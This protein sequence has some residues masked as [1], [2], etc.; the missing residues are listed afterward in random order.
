MDSF[1]PTESRVP[2]RI[3]DPTHVHVV[4]TRRGTPI[5]VPVRAGGYATQRAPSHGL[6]FH[7]GGQPDTGFF[8]TAERLWEALDLVIDLEDEEERR[9][10]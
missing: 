6:Y 2:K 7:Y 10:G 9:R 1:T 3:P 8:V 4:V 5:Q